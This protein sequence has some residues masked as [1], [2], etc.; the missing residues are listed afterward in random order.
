RRPRRGEVLPVSTTLPRPETQT[1]VLQNYIDG[2][3]TPSASSDVHDVVNP[4]TGEVFARVPLSTAAEVEQA[5]AA[6]RRAFESWRQHPVIERARWLFGFR[7][8]LHERRDELAAS[9]TREMGKTY[10]DARAEVARMIEMVECATA[11]P[12][13][14]QGRTLE[15]VATNVDCETIR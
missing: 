11:I 2:A 10:P 7:Q 9:V 12:T 4:A 15:G 14:M 1:R 13:T 8:A 3:W 5:V 6:A